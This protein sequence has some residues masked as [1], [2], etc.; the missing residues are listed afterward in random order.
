MSTS[1]LVKNMNNVANLTAI[2]NSM[3][4]TLAVKGMAS[5]N[6]NLEAGT[7]ALKPQSAY[8]TAISRINGGE[9]SP[10]IGVI[11]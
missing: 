3:K 4:P 2:A 1:K 5:V 7:A 6:R 8:R 10:L 9:L 11:L